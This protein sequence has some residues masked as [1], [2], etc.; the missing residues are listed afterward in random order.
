M[1]RPEVGIVWRQVGQWYQASAAVSIQRVLKLPEWNYAVAGGIQVS[2]GPYPIVRA[3]FGG[4]F[5]I[6]WPVDHYFPVFS[7]IEFRD[8][9]FLRRT[10]K[11]KL[12]RRRRGSGFFN[13]SGGMASKQIKKDRKQHQGF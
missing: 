5:V 11:I 3:V 6:E 10:G 4:C 9:Y 8:F 13:L 7:A 1:R 2:Q 12:H